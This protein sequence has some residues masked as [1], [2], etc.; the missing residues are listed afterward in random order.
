MNNKIPNEFIKVSAT[1]SHHG[2]NEIVNI[3]DG[4]LDT[5]YASSGKYGAGSY[6]DIYF[7]FS[8]HKAVEGVE[9]Y[10]SN[11]RGWGLVQRY[12]ILYKNN[13]STAGW[14]SIYGVTEVEGS[15]GWRTAQFSPVLA[16]EIFMQAMVVLSL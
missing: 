16:K 6:G 2:N 7:T 1:L 10:T 9:F 4:D 11:S 14:T 12:E 5:M 15:E 3:L 8:N 13:L